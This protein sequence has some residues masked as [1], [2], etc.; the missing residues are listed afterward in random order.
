MA[1]NY[2]LW[3]HVIKILHSHQEYTMDLC[4]G[5]HIHETYKV[6]LCVNTNHKYS[7]TTW[8]KKDETQ[9]LQSRRLKSMNLTM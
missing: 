9:R 5:K 6:D 3:I 8:A 1:T 2:T 4:I 7:S